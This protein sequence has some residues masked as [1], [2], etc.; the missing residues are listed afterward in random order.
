MIKSDVESKEVPALNAVVGQCSLIRIAFVALLIMISTA[1]LT[2]QITPTKKLSDD[3]SQIDLEVAIPKNFGVWKIDP[4]MV[5]IMPSPDQSQ[6]LSET[7]DQVVN[8]TYVNDVGERVMLSVAY[9][10]SQKQGLRA[11]RQEVCYRAQGF[12]I[13]DLKR[14]DFPV[15]G[16]T[17]Q[18]VQLIA[19][20]GNRVEPITYWFTMGDHVVRSY[21]ERQVVQLQY[22]LSGYIPDG[23]LFRVS[24]L[25]RD[26]ADSDLHTRFTEDLMK[27]LP[28][29]LRDRLI[30]K[31]E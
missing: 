14:V 12:R 1:L 3:Q 15:L 13:A 2:I 31:V 30:G 28:A 29:E 19:S 24:T 6:A 4:T 21:W 20:Y 10:S 22:A 17:L 16:Q 25:G 23:Y 5:P 7:Y 27:S 9:G 18:A 11:H 26:T 8:H